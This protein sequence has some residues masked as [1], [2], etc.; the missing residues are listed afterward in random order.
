MRTSIL[1]AAVPTILGAAF[2]AGG[3]RSAQQVA[4]GPKYFHHAEEYRVAPKPDAP[5]PSAAE[6]VVVYTV[7]PGRPIRLQSVAL[8]LGL[9]ARTQTEGVERVPLGLGVMVDTERAAPLTVRFSASPWELVH[10]EPGVLLEPGARL[11]LRFDE[12]V[13]ALRGALFLNGTYE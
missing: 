1:I 7:P 3:L 6:N 9:S 8:P 11:C 4:A 2:Y 5:L 12:P 10:L 13:K